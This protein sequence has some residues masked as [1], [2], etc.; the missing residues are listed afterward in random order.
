MSII[1]GPR[2][3]SNFYMLDKRISEDKRLGWAARGLLIYLLGK[4]DH[5]KVSVPALI[6][7]TGIA[8]MKTGRD[9][10]YRIL[11]ELRL[12]GYVRHDRIAATATTKAVC[13]WVVSEACALASRAENPDEGRADNPDGSRAENPD[14]LVSI[15]S[16]R[17]E[18]NTPTIPTGIQALPGLALPPNLLG[19]PKPAA[20][21]AALTKTQADDL[22]ETWNT[23]C[24]RVKK[25][26]RVNDAR[27]AL[28][29]KRFK[30]EFNSDPAEWE[31][32][33]KRCARS[34]FLT[35]DNDRNWRPPTF[36]WMMKPEKIMNVF[37][38]VYDD[39]SGNQGSSAPRRF[40]PSPGT[41]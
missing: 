39:K 18:K 10:V 24:A 41:I 8:G 30:E 37:E 27:R 2:P 19:S 4:P 21:K 40:I 11:E 28:V 13:Q 6:A 34:P 38:G 14:V 3:D 16:P 5:W 33:C 25:A 35:G 32:F 1:R 36:D 12:A 9:G 29:M 7:E 20:T 23:I 31:K 17:T 22:I 15:E 26:T